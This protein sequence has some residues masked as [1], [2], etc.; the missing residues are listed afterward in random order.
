MLGEEA[1]EPARD[2]SVGGVEGLGV[3]I[4]D[5]AYDVPVGSAGRKRQRPA[6]GD[7]KQ[8]PLRIEDVEQWEEVVLVRTAA[9]EEHER[10]LG[11]P[12]GGPIQ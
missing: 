4:A 8:A 11:V 5:A 1:V 12:C 2:L 9:V 10:S 7:A 6:G 3:G